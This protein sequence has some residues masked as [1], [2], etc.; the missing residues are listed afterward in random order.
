M[1]IKATM[2][3]YWTSLVIP[4]KSLPVRSLIGRR[5]TALTIQ[6]RLFAK[7][8]ITGYHKD[9]EN[10]WVAQLQ[11]GH[12]QHVRHDPPLVERLWVLTKEGR[13]SFL[14][15]DLNCVKCDAKAPKDDR[16]AQKVEWDQTR[17]TR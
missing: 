13:D 8:A 2:A 16:P 14:G 15:H 3:L 9:E 17:S 12:N 5:S 10:H 4:C 7:Q 6:T 11:C 1:M